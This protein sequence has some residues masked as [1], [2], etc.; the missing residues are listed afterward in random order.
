MI[1]VD[2]LVHSF[3]FQIDNGVPIAEWIDD[4]NDDE[5]VGL[6]NYLVEASKA[7][8]IREFNRGRLKLRELTNFNLEKY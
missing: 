5:L 8:D 6:G 7:P 3:G 4:Q 2:N 1:I